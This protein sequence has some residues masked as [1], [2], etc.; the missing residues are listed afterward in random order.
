[1]TRSADK[2]E[3]LRREEEVWISGLR[4]QSDDATLFLQHTYSLLS[5]LYITLSF[6]ISSFL[7]S[8]DLL[9]QSFEHL[10]ARLNNLPRCT[11][12]L[13]NAGDVGAELFCLLIRPSRLKCHFGVAKAVGAIGAGARS[14]AIP[15]GYFANFLNP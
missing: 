9:L 13:W 1:M 2:P 10:N 11:V 8:L 12:P 15:A 14:L 7:F 3:N 5:T 6:L 4:Q